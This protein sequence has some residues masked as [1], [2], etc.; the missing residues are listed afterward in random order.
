[1]KMLV[2]SEFKLPTFDDKLMDCMTDFR[3]PLSAAAECNFECEVDPSLFSQLLPYNVDMNSYGDATSFTL[4]FKTPERVQARRH[5]KKRINKKWAKRYGY[6]TVFRN[7][8]MTNV[9]FDPV[10]TI[11]EDGNISFSEFSI[12]GGNYIRR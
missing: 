8:R 5:K 9:H 2:Q 3:I 11:R 6:K 7:V 1:M 10:Y 4:T 12:V